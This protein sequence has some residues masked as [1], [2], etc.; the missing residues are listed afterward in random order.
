MLE[1][2]AGTIWY[3]MPEVMFSHIKSMKSDIWSLG[4]SIFLTLTGGFPFDW[5]EEVDV[6]TEIAEGLPNTPDILAEYQ[7]SEDCQNLF[8]SM[9]NPDPDQFLIVTREKFPKPNRPVTENEVTQRSEG[10]RSGHTYQ[11]HFTVNSQKIQTI[12]NDRRPR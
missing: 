12:F 1:T 10:L 5:Q 7:I 8:V 2:S 3:E 6:K 4:I 9:C 11:K